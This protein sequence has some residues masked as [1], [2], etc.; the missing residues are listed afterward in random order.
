MKFKVRDLSKSFFDRDYKDNPDMKRVREEILN[1]KDFKWLEKKIKSMNLNDLRTSDYYFKRMLIEHKVILE[2]YDQAKKKF[3]EKL[4]SNVKQ[5]NRNSLKRILPLLEKLK[6]Y[7]ESS[8]GPSVIFS[9]ARK[10]L[11]TI[12]NK[13]YVKETAVAFISRMIASD[14]PSTELLALRD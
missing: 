9:F 2:E 4:T 10:I 8:S 14:T 1:P 5:Y 6:L 11:R 12:Q 13:G 3:S 7:G